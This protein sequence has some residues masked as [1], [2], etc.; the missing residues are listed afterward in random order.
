MRRTD[1]EIT[2][3]GAISRIIGQCQVCRLGLAKDNRP[4]I[5]PVSFGYDGSALYFHT[6][7]TGT[8]I[9]FITANPGVCFEFEYGVRLAPHETDPC[10]W[11]FSYQSVIG[12][13]TVRELADPEEK[14]DGL[15][16]IMKQYSEKEWTFTAVSLEAISVWK[17]E[18]ESM[19]GKQSKD[20][21]TS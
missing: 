17:V 12:Y 16:R 5:I 13:G 9:D 14:A 1:K 20:H 2:D 15:R 21:F 7:K 8:K 11:T 10:N 3:Q 18:I 4:Y 19:T 6:A